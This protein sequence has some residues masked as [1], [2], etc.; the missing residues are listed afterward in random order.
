MI[1]YLPPKKRSGAGRLRK[2]CAPFKTNQ[3]KLYGAAATVSEPAP[4]RL[5]RGD[6]MEALQLLETRR[7]ERQQHW[8]DTARI[9]VP[10]HVSCPYERWVAFVG[11][12]ESVEQYKT[13]SAHVAVAVWKHRCADGPVTCIGH[14]FEQSSGE[15]WVTVVRVGLAERAGSAGSK[16]ADVFSETLDM[17]ARAA[18]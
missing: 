13:S 6:F 14:L 18:F 4:S 17:W 2:P 5:S 3:A 10:V 15:R 12:P 8:A 7:G 1:R 11:E 9:M 16:R